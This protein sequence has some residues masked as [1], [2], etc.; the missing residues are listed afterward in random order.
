MQ[1]LARQ[2]S[3]AILPVEKI[4]AEFRRNFKFD[5]DLRV[6]R[7]F[8][9]LRNFFC[10]NFRMKIETDAIILDIDGTLWNTTGV[11][12]QAWNKAIE[13]LNLPA[14]KV[15]AQ[16]LKNEFGKP[17]DKIADS[18]WPNLSKAQ[19]TKLMNEC[20]EQEQIALIVNEKKIEFPNVVSTIKKLSERFNIYIVSNCQSGYIE[21][22][23]K[24]IG[25][26]NFIRD[27]ECYGDT[28][29][30]KAENL[31]LLCE[32][33]HLKKPVYVGDTEGDREACKEAGI[34]FIWA[35]YGFGS[36]RTYDVKIENF[37][38]LLDLLEPIKL[39]KTFIRA[40]VPDDAKEL[41]AIYAP[42]VKN[43]A[44]SFECAVPSV[45]NFKKRISE[46]LKTYPYLVLVCENEILG[47][48]YAAPFKNRAAYN[49]CVE[50]TIYLK[51]GYA[52][53][54]L[55]KKL[56]SALENILRSQNI[57]NMNACIAHAS[58]SS[59]YLTNA[60]EEFHKKMGFKK[61]AHFSQC[62]FKF[63]KWFDMIWMQ[64]SLGA[65][66]EKTKDIIPFSEL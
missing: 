22:T 24:K 19:K 58:K 4:I 6:A 28:K 20:C 11:V 39:P 49:W 27:H 40:A 34:K 59:Q 35:S 65:H 63:G 57:L 31:R 7:S 48:A 23:M 10:Y 26:E 62:G 46:T 14:R 36:A 61:A 42:Y 43:T 38:E 16:N 15:N 50:T 37:K 54:G 17:M 9:D 13:K 29:K 33:N 64:K 18:L 52:Q 32:R 30:N 3:S 51:Q 25:I 47:Y 55:G 44:I 2:I 8:V 45:A 21:L 1:I 66:T 56:Y 60:S 12:A 41:L 53:R 5:L